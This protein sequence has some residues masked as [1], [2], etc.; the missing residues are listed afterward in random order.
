LRQECR[1][2]KAVNIDTYLERCINVQKQQQC[3]VCLSPVVLCT[4]TI[5]LSGTAIAYSQPLSSFSPSPLHSPHTLC[6]GTGRY[7]YTTTSP[8]RRVSAGGTSTGE[9]ERTREQEMAALTLFKDVGTTAR[10]TWG[11]MKKSVE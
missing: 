1:P 11:G 5:H 9:R 6:T 7:Q 8:D 3:C 4:T 2:P 10:Y